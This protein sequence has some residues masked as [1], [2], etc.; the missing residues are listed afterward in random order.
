M[1]RCPLR[2][3]GNRRST[4]VEGA[5]EQARGAVRPH[6]QPCLLRDT[7]MWSP[8]IKGYRVWARRAHV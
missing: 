6:R 4:V 2:W 1:P 3:A 8:W 5:G 7:S